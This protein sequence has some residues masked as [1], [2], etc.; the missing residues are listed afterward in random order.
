[1]AERPTY[2]LYPASV[3][4][5][6]VV[7]H[8][9]RGGFENSDICMVLSPAHP[10][11]DCVRESDILGAASDRALSARMITWF[12]KRGAVLIPTVGCFVSS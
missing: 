2:W 11:A 5:P 9:N 8:L 1:M 7:G 3:P 10:D 6:E 4:L 12:S